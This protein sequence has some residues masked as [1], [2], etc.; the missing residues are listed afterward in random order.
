MMAPLF[1]HLGRDP[2][3]AGL[4]KNT[5]PSVFR[6]TERMNSPAL[7]DSD[8]PQEPDGFP[9][10]DAL[11]DS[12]IP[13]IACAVA[14][15][16]PGLRADTECFNRWLAALDDPR[17]GRLVSHDGKRQVH[18]HVGRISYPWR[19]V[20][21]ERASHPHSLWHF[22]RAQAAVQA[23]TGSDATRFETLMGNVGGNE[24]FALR[25]D[26]KISRKD[27]VLVLA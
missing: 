26:R 20:T 21:M 12:L 8:Y 17:P 4:M 5:A 10:D 23:L 1:A 18:P 3:P 9:A 15:W 16:T 13:V 24:L 27:N 2:V 7:A 6:W 11:P 25:T 19:E 14:Q 22:A